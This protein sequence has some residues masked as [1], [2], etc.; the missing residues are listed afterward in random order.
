MP[1]L[2]DKAISDLGLYRVREDGLDLTGVTSVT[3]TAR[4]EAGKIVHQVT[5]ELPPEAI[6]P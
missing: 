4:N 6:A 5:H 3:L 1:V 2:P